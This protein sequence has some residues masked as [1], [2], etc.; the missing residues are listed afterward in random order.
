MKDSFTITVTGKRPDFVL[1]HM[2]TLTK[3]Y[4]YLHRICSGPDGNRH[5]RKERDALH[6][7]LKVLR[8]PAENG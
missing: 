2:D 3:R 4:M 7:V 6:W 5:Q 8:T 1:D